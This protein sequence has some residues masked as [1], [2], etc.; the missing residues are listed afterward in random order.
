MRICEKCRHL[1]V[2]REDGR[3]YSVT[4][5][6]QQ[7]DFLDVCSP[8]DPY[9]EEFWDVV[10]QYFNS[11][12]PA[13]MQMPGGRYECARVLANRNLLFLQGFSLGQVCHIVQLAI[14][15]RR[16]LGYREGLLVPY[17]FSDSWAKEQCAFIHSPTGQEC[18]PTVNWDE[19]HTLL[20]QLLITHQQ[21]EPAGITLSNLKRLFRLH[22]QRELS[23]TVLG[24]IRLVD[25]MNDPRLS[26]ICIM[27]VQKNSQIVVKAKETC[28]LPLGPAVPPGMG[29]IV[30]HACAMPPLAVMVPSFEE[31]LMSP[32]ASPRGSPLPGNEFSGLKNSATE[33][34]IEGSLESV[35]SSESGDDEVFESPFS[36]QEDVEKSP[37]WAVT[38]KNTFIDV[39]PTEARPLAACARHRRRS[40]PASEFRAI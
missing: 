4:M 2:A 33:S 27:C 16:L 38:V 9:S 5:V 35:A 32:G 1:N 19:A 34:T 28:R 31:G 29:T 21:V 12:G 40:V 14:T 15:Q 13:E 3:E 25:L 17:M 26:D 36:V 24:H 6:G 39:Q 18:C 11:L 30:M 23:E 10:T 37:A 20:H 8:V 7:S 22:F